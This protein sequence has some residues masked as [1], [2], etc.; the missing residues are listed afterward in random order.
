MCADWRRANVEQ[1]HPT[2]DERERGL[3]TTPAEREKEDIGNYTWAGVRDRRQAVAAELETR[4]A[5]GLLSECLFEVTNPGAIGGNP[6]QPVEFVGADPAQRAVI[7]G[8]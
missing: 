5:G 1:T 6:W 4:L 2:D 3:S 8:L 7:V